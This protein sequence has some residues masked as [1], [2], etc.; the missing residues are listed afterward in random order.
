MLKKITLIGSGN[1][2]HNLGHAFISHGIEIVE[3]YSRTLKNAK[4]LA[5][6]LDSNYTSDLSKINKESDLYII[7]SSD[8]SI[9]EIAEQLNLKDRLVVHTSGSVGIEV[10]KSTTSNYGSFYPLQTFTKSHLTDFTN[11]PF[12]I[13][14]NSN[15]YK[16]DLIELAYLLSNRVIEMDSEQRSNLHLAA[17]FTSNFSNYMQVIAQDI[18]E[19]KEVDFNLL[20]PLIKE[21]FEKNLIDKAEKNQTGPALRDDEFTMNKHIDL[22]KEDKETQD[23]Y[24]LISSMIT[25]R[26]N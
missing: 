15:K 18:C 14:G 5:L 7:A 10:L 12:C 11:V 9:I 2:A 22:L 24:T 3:V 26:F 19:S 6:Q 8:D 1:V 21:V 4:L 13:E 23:L 20:K 25:K 16:K 17:V